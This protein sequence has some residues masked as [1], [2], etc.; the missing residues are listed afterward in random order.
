PGSELAIERI[1]CG[2]LLLAGAAPGRPD[3]DQGDLATIVLGERE[4]VAGGEIH[5]ARVG[6]IGADADRSG[7]DAAPA[8]GEEAEK[9][10][11]VSGHGVAAFRRARTAPAM[12]GWPKTAVP[13]TKVSAPAAQA[14]AMVPVVMPPST[15]RIAVE[16]WASSSARTRAIFAVLAGR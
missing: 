4:G 12:S 8:E 1:E 16:R 2:D 5:H 6:G 11:G 9:R 3:V 14:A 7:V 10:E 15:S 13:A